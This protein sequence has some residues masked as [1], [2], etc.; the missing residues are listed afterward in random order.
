M[1][2]RKS[3]SAASSESSVF[4]FDYQPLTNAFQNLCFW[5]LKAM[6]L[7]G[8]SYAFGGQK[9][10]FWKNIVKTFRFRFRKF[11]NKS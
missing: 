10:C 8:E 5:R 1:L 4:L 7:K 9:L 6:L 3:K 11:K 2:I